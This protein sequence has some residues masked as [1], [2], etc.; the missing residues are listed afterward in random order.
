MES[1]IIRE[2]KM[3]VKSITGVSEP[4]CGELTLT[5]REI[6]YIEL[7]RSHPENANLAYQILMQSLP[8]DEHLHSQF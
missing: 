3:E 8:N 6:E 1:V 4:P 7:L 2:G 5:Q